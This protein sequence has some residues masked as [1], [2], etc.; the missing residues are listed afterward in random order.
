MNTLTIC[1]LVLAGCIA[2]AAAQ[3]AEENA[4][5]RITAD[6]QA[7][8]AEEDACLNAELAWGRT[9]LAAVLIP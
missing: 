8:A 5:A 4:L 3:E 6:V 9:W 7:Q 1:A 2:P